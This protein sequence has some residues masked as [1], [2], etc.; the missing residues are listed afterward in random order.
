VHTN[1]L[2]PGVLLRYGSFKLPGVEFGL[3]Y[4]IVKDPTAARVRQGPESY[5]WGGLF[6]T[7]HWIDPI[8]DMIVIGL[9]NNANGASPTGA[10]RGREISGALVYKALL[11]T[12]S[13]E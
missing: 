9:I 7:W 8:N 10:P 1:A 11:N 6:G 4:A 5:F 3:G 13:K 2:E 12:S